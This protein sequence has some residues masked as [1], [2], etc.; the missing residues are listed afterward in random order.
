MPRFKNPITGEII[1]VT[2]DFAEQVLRPQ[3]RY[4]EVKEAPIKVVAPIVKKKVS[5]KKSRAK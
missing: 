1:E 2:E 3:G 4:V 5:K